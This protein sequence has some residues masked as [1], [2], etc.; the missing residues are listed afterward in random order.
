MFNLVVTNVPGPQHPVYAARARVLSSA[1]V[2]PL[3]HGQGLSVAVTSYDGDLAFG[4]LA[5]RDLLPDLP[6]LVD[7]VAA[8]LQE[9]ADDL[10]DEP[11]PDGF[12]AP[13]N[14]GLG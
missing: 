13:L 5:D 14:G 6:V 9:L 11:L 4:F 8:A 3:A 2:I 1:P 10:P 12:D 7:C